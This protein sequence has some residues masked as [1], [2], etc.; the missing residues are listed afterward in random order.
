VSIWSIIRNGASIKL[1]EIVT[2]QADESINTL[3][4]FC[5]IPRTRDEMQHFMKISHRGYFFK[6]ILNP[7]IEKGLIKLQ[8]PDKPISPNQKYYS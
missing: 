1:K 8:I 7:L 3:I 4:E 2:V 6:K 5:K